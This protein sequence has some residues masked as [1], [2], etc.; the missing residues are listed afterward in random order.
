MQSFEIANDVSD[1]MILID[2]DLLV[3]WILDVDKIRLEMGVESSNGRVE[4]SLALRNSSNS[5]VHVLT[6]RLE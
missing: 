4:D 2:G 6:R 1:F 3:S 5:S